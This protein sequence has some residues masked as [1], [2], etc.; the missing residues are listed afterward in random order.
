MLAGSAL[1]LLSLPIFATA[2]WPLAAWGLAAALWIAGE[3]L[4]YAL[5]RMPLGVDNLAASGVAGVGMTFR[6][7]AVMI[8][9]LIVATQ[10]RHV[11]LAAGLVYIAA[12]S[13]EFALSLVAYFG[14]KR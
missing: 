10:H 8:I 2:G 1:V 4:A 11:A 7:M 12:Y 9:L 13:V 14:A 5:A 3:G 6:A